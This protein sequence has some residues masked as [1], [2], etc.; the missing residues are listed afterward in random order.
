M[1]SPKYPSPNGL[2]ASCAQIASVH[3]WS[4]AAIAAGP[5]ESPASSACVS[6]SPSPSVVRLVQFRLVCGYTFSGFPPDSDFRQFDSLTAVPYDTD[7]TEA[8]L[9]SASVPRCHGT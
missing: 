5:T 8:P 4:P 9:T 2:V 7:A 6:V 1:V 3:A